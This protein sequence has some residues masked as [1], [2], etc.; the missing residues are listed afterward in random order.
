MG[1]QPLRNPG[2]NPSQPTL[3][4]L[5]HMTGH[6][7]RR[8]PQI[9]LPAFG[10]R[11]LHGLI[12]SPLPQL[13]KFGLRLHPLQL[14][15]LR[16]IRAALAARHILAYLLLHGPFGIPHHPGAIPLRAFLQQS[17]QFLVIL[18]VRRAARGHAQLA[19][20]LLPLLSRFFPR[21]HAFL[22]A[23]DLLV[24]DVVQK[25]VAL[26]KD[27]LVEMSREAD[28][29]RVAGFVFVG[30]DG[31]ADAGGVEVGSTAGEVVASFGGHFGWGVFGFL[32][33]SIIVV[34]VIV[35]FVGRRLFHG[36][37][38]II[39]ITTTGKETLFG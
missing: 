28:H 19:T 10:N 26:A 23:F 6:L 2:K 34:I 22:E 29:A 38:I 31:D 37:I 30:A 39:I 25:S 18:L 17:F 8:L 27:V 33:L 13:V 20:F 5:D 36:A 7:F 3:S 35:V 1:Q 12:P 14:G 32:F 4:S 9:L 15:T 21:P 11:L 16:I 24:L